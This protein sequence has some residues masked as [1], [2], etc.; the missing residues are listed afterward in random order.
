MDSWPDVIY[1]AVGTADGLTDIYP[2]TWN[3]VD[4]DEFITAARLMAGAIRHDLLPAVKGEACGAGGP[5]ECG[6]LRRC[7]GVKGWERFYKEKK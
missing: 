4:Y 2:Y 7:Y 3:D 5:M 6:Y 1:F